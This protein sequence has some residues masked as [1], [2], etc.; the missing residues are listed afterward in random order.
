MTTGETSSGSFAGSSALKTA[1]RWMRAAAA[2]IIAFAFLA[3]VVFLAA[4]LTATALVIAGLALLA[5]GAYWLWMKLRG[6]RA[7]MD[8]RFEA[9]TTKP[10]DEAKPGE[11]EVLVARRGPHGWTIERA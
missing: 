1:G 3:L 10:E 5:G 7:E 11:G 6:G 4:A 9:H 8:V 2:A